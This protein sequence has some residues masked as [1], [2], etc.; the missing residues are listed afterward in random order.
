[1][2]A[3]FVTGAGTEIGKTYVACALLRA[4]REAGVA[5]GAFKPVVSGFDANHVS[6]SDPAQLLA[7]LGVHASAEAMAAMSPWRF[8]APLAPPLAAKAEGVTLAFG[9]IEGA[10]RARLRQSADRMLLIEG[11]GGVMAP[12]TEGET[13]LDLIAALGTPV[14]FVAGSY[15]GAVSH[16]LTGLSVL[17]ARGIATRAIVVS[18]SEASVGLEATCG[19]IARIRAR[20]H[21]VAAP[22]TTSTDWAADLARRLA[23]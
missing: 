3:L 9:A 7:A 5:C 8:K 4:W 18:E 22:R 2:S 14:V 11:A 16:A 19:M 21:I 12:L 10:C 13:N 1:V 20:D 15:L 6:A 23:V 17:D